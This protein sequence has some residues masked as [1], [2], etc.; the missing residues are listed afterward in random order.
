MTTILKIS[1]SAE[2]RAA[3]LGALRDAGLGVIE[4]DDWEAASEAL[5]NCD[6]ALVVCDGVVLEGV[7]TEKLKKALAS[8]SNVKTSSTLPADLARALSHE[9]RTPL[10][11]MAGWLHLMESGKLD[12]D[13][14]KRAIQKLRGNIDDQVRTIDRYLG[15]TST[16]RSG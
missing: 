13:A 5:R 4:V 14:M 10:S 11:A 2:G 15:T 12:G 16:G 9:L 7:D 1:K 3:A 8:L 6:A